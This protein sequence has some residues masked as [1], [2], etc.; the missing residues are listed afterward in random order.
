MALAFGRKGP[1]SLV[2]TIFDP[3]SEVKVFEKIEKRT[4]HK[5]RLVFGNL[6]VTVVFWGGGKMAE[7]LR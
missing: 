4:W 7:E 2:G 6:G 3:F 5:G 1:S